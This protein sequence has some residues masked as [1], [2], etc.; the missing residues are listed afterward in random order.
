MTWAIFGLCEHPEFQTR[1]REEISPFTGMP[2]YD[3]L[4]SLPFLDAVV[5]ET[6]RMYPPFPAVVRVASK[7]TV[8]PLSSEAPI[9]DAKGVKRDSIL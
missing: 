9:T 4:N 2:S 5:R 8:L 6:L 1:L 7:D 3:E